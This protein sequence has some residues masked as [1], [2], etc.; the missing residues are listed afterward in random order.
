[1][2][3]IA[4][5]ITVNTDVTI[6]VARNPEAIVNLIQFLIFITVLYIFQ[7]FLVK[8]LEDYPKKKHWNFLGVSIIILILISISSYIQFI[9]RLE[10][11]F[12]FVFLSLIFILTE[13]LIKLLENKNSKKQIDYFFIVF[14]CFIIVCLMI[15]FANSYA[16]TNLIKP[17]TDWFNLDY[18]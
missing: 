3:E 18:S 11:V 10:H 13:F 12:V 16:P 8:F 15:Y 17:I 2:V 6:A 1:M 5:A 4:D 14:I 9:F 7:H